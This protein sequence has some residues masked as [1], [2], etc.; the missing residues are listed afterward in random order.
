MV[1]LRQGQGPGGNTMADIGRD[2]R[3]LLH[4]KHSKRLD[5]AT[6]ALARATQKLPD[7]ES[8]AVVAAVC[9]LVMLLH[10]KMERQIQREDKAKST[11]TF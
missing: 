10:D 6:E 4:L 11:I 7:D 3:R 2:I 5:E 9:N 1:F 8:W